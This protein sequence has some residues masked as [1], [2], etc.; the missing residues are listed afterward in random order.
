MFCLWKSPQAKSACHTNVQCITTCPSFPSDPGPEMSSHEQMHTTNFPICGGEY[1]TAVLKLTVNISAAQY[2]VWKTEQEHLLLMSS[3]CFFLT[4]HS[5]STFSFGE[6]PCLLL[7]QHM[8]S[9][10]IFMVPWWF[11]LTHDILPPASLSPF[12]TTVHC[13]IHP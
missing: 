9:A 1:F 7:Y 3:P 10:F 12:I 5:Q 4:N 11:R 8:A 13:T 6:R 2:C